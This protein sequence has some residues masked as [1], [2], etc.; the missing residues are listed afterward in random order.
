MKKFNLIFFILIIFTANASAQLPY[1]CKIDIGININGVF[2]YSTEIP[3][4]NMMKMSRPWYTKAV[5]DPADP[6]STNLSDFLDYDANGYP[7]H[8]PQTIPG[9]T[10][11]QDV[12]TI[13]DGMD[14]WPT[15]TYTLLW[16]GTGDF[17]IWGSMTNL[18][19]INSNRY[20]FDVVTPEDGVLEIRMILSD[21]NDPVQNMRLLI[22][23]TESTYTTQPFNQEWLDGLGTFSTIR[24]M[25]WGHTNNW[26]QTDENWDNPTLASWSERA[27]LEYYTYSSR[28]GVP[29]EL[30]IQL[31]NHLDVDGWV[32]IPHRA[33][34]DYIT[35]MA[36]MFRDQCESDRHIY[37]EYS[38]EIWNWIF[39]QTHWLNQYGCID[40]NIS[41]PEGLVPYV[42][43]ALDLWT[44]SFSNEMNRITR[45]AGVQIGWLDVS[46]RIC[47]N[48]T[49]NSIDAISPTFYFSYTE[50]DEELLDNLGSNATAL[51]VANFANQGIEE[52]FDYIKGIKTIADSLDLPL[53]FYEGGQHLTPTPFGVMPTYAD[54]LLEVQTIPEMYDLYT[55]WIDSIRTLN[56]REEP[57]LLCHFV[58]A[59]KPSAQ[60]GSWGLLERSDQDLSIMPAPKYQ[61]FIEADMCDEITSTSDLV[62]EVDALT[63]YPNPT[64]GIFKIEGMTSQYEILVLDI[65]GN[66]HQDLTNAIDQD[67]SIDLSSLPSG[68]Y[69]I[70]VQSI[71]NNTVWIEKIIKN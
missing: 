52:S 39:G 66:I 16:D 71:S 59:S 20:E 2:D 12:A 51:D 32:C 55:E 44:N 54:A 1:S 26:G 7:T 41:W 24:F 65:L 38:N 62:L 29:Y 50:S 28:K 49:P 58:F 17:S 3:F 30:M 10:Y 31:I 43:N 35:Q 56:T 53:A 63:L 4:A 13:W 33:S 68:M 14:A 21:I 46:E 67:I 5:N 61:A 9:E 18:T 34:N 23:G 6:F 57:M 15:G 25:D 70:S 42:Q 47:Y 27:Q 69:F 40:Q 64:N 11:Q 48:L 19:M 22:P 45:V 8:I 37:V 36:N 60:F